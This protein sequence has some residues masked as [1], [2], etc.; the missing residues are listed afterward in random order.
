MPFFFSTLALLAWELFE[1]TINIIEPSLNVATDIVIG[2][3]GFLFAAYFYYFI[4][5]SVEMYFYPVL[6][7]TSLLAFWGFFDFLKRGYR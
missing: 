3:V 7:S 2:L 4:E 5:S 1:W 6:V